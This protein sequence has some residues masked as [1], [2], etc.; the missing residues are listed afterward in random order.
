V[1]QQTR[2]SGASPKEAGSASTPATG[3]AARRREIAEVIADV[4]LRRAQ[5]EHLPDAAVLAGRPDLQPG[6]QDELGAL[7]EIHR[8]FLEAQKAG[9]A[10]A[11]IPHDSDPLAARL[12]GHA[13]PDPQ[14]LPSEPI[15]GYTVMTEASSGGQGA[16]FR[17]RH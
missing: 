3:E 17:A 14:R 10:S 9:P 13:R 7:R 1:N 4:A 8:T 15:A 11:A 12:P 5:G 2:G 6:L 16:V